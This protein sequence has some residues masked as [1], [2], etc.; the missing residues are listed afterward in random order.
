MVS[1]YQGSAYL[2]DGCNASHIVCNV[3]HLV[4]TLPCDVIHLVLD[5]RLL[6]HMASYDA[7]SFIHL[8]VAEA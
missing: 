4:D 7:A 8:A 5:R 2:Q 6:S 3:I 1:M